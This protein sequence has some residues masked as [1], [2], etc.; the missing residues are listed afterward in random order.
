MA[1]QII[2]IDSLGS[3]GGS[4]DPFFATGVPF[5]ANGQQPHYDLLVQ[6]LHQLLRVLAPLNSLRVYQDDSAA[7]TVG[8][9]AGRC[10]IG[11]SVLVYTGGTVS[12]LADNDT[13]LIWAED[14]SGF[15]IGSAVDGTGWPGG[16]HL[17]LAEVTVVGGVITQIL[18]RRIE[19]MLSA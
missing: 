17:K 7:T 5:I 9:A 12:G 16:T 10:T 11:G 18:D 15:A 8:I 19:R 4:A 1:E 2:S 6:Q 13:T 3:P 14:S